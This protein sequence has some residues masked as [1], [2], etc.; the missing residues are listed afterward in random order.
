MKFQYYMPARIL[1]GAGS[2]QKL[3][4]VALP[5]KKALLITGGTS[6]TRLGYVDTVRAAL[7]AGGAETVVY[8]KVSPNPTLTNV[9]ECA[10]IARS[11]QCD[12]VVGLG[13]GSS[14]DTAKAA[15]VAATNDGDYWDYVFGGSGKRQPVKNQP[16]PIVA[17]TTTAGTGTESDPWTVVTKEETN[18]KIGFGF[19]STFPTLS[20]VDPDL[21][22]SVPAALTA[23]QGFDALFHAVEGY[24]ASIANPM[25]DMFALK[26][27]ELL[28]RNLA[29]AVK[30]G[31]DKEAR[32]NVALANTLSGFVETLSSCT[33]EHAM[34]HA[35][36]AFH[37]NLPHGAGLIMISL[38]YF[39]AFSGACAE[40]F[41]DMA[42]ALGQPDASDPMDFV[43]A[44]K[45]LQEDCGVAQLKMSDY[46][47]DGEHMDK[48]TENALSTMGALFKMD[49]MTLSKEQVNGIYKRSYR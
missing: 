19:D 14:I 23:Y 7:K 3:G 29:K 26:S 33:S 6:T 11:E 41:I 47:I 30:N 49:V 46:G 17:I 28:G 43:R 20:V 25:S 40:R 1:F 35:L 12:F 34:E 48:Y 10:G 24:I 15:A 2:V 22:M 16:L 13:G 32:A 8:D 4:K 36:S 27:I 37:P 31:E 18:E 45:K 38:E 9:M 5:G 21:M 42:R 44:L 39:T